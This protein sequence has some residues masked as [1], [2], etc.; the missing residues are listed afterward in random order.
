MLINYI[1]TCLIFQSR[2]EDIIKDLSSTHH[3]KYIKR[4]PEDQ[5]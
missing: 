4:I 1:M 5:V 3:G 2:V